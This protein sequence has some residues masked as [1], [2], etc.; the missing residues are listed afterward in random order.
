MISAKHLS[1]QLTTY[2]LDARRVACVDHVL[3]S[4]ATFRDEQVGD[5]LIIRPP[6]SA[7]TC[8]CV[9]LT[10]EGQQADDRRG[11][12]IGPTLD[13]PVGSRTKKVD[14]FRSKVLLCPFIRTSE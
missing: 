11:R 2:D 14:K 5:G 1:F 13:E 12:Y 3:E 6:F 9:G 8:S 10:W 7:W 4:V